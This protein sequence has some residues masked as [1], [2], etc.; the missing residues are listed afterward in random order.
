[1]RSSVLIPLFAIAAV[2]IPIVHEISRTKH[3]AKR[4]L[5]MNSTA[6][7][8]FAALVAFGGFIW[9]GGIISK[10]AINYYFNKQVMHDEERLKKNMIAEARVKDIGVKPQHLEARLIDDVYLPM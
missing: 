3:L 10:R 4:N 2:A 7:I 9:S 5:N 6:E 8:L 1:M